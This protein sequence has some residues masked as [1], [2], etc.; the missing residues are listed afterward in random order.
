MGIPGMATAGMGDVLA[1]LAASLIAQ[2]LDDMPA[3]FC[4]ADT[5]A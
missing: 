1:G 3:A 4:T 5:A 2:Q